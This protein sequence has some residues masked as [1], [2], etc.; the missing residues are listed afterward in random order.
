MSTNPWD[1]PPELPIRA[2][3][4]E[5]LEPFI[6][7]SLFGESMDGMQRP[8]APVRVLVGLPVQRRDAAGSKFYAYPIRVKLANGGELRT[9][10]RYSEFVALHAE[11]QVALALPEGFVVPQL[12]LPTWTKAFRRA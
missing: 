10:R 2:S 1:M 11:V 4:S 3:T 6:I 7:D 12:N 8:P 5:R 9:E